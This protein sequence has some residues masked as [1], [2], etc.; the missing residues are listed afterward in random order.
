MYNY[1][2]DAKQASSFVVNKNKEVYSFLDFDNKKDFEDASKGFIATIDDNFIRDEKGNVVYDT[3]IHSFLDEVSEMDAPNTVNPSLWRQGRLTNLNGLFKVVDGIYQIRSFDLANMTAIRGNTG[4]ILIDVLTC[5]ETAKAGMDLL[6]KHVEDL[7]IKA[8]IYTHSHLD[9]F[10]GIKGIVTQEEVDNGN[11]EIIAPYNFTFETGSENVIAGNAMARRAD[12]QGG[13]SVE[14]SPQGGVGIGLGAGCASGKVTLIKPT[15]EL[16]NEL[17]TKLTIDGVDFEFTECN[18]T[19]AVSEFII[20]VPKYETLCTSEV[21]CHNL[22]N[23][24][25]PRGAQ[26]RSSLKWA[27]SIDNM[28]R[29][30]GDRTEYIVA[31]H[32]WPTFGNKDCIDFLEKQR[33]IYLY[34]HNETVRLIN[35]GVTIRELP[36]EF[37]L[38]PELEKTWHTRGYYG[39]INHNV[40]AIYQF[41]LG[42]Y[43]ANPSTNLEIHPSEAGEKLIEMMD[44]VENILAKCSKYMENGD[45]YW[46]CE[47]LNKVVFARPDNE[48]VK[49][50]L[51]DALEQIGYMEE[52][53]IRRNMYL[54]GAFELRNGIKQKGGINLSDDLMVGLT[55]EQILDFIGVRYNA[56]TAS[57]KKLKIKFNFTDLNET[58]IL[59]LTNNRV[60]NNFISDEDALLTISGNKLAIVALLTSPN[61][62]EL[63]EKGIIQ[64]EGDLSQIQLLASSCDKFAPNFAIVTP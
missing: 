42:W 3:K 41:Y 40:K 61:A 63:L 45:F 30:Y 28:I 9:H 32:H 26:I 22:H 51:A 62:S 29:L 2:K 36:H 43:D 7:P 47:V 64:T 24:L 1:N 20:F 6:R 37:K 23:L 38:S 59:E 33:D 35:N 8:V 49:C 44:G 14:R 13:F 57:N 25:T 39:H 58:R 54:Q 10:G 12:Y 27:K 21:A 50:M 56:L 19:E 48:N 18:E 15:L 11:V 4:W 60:L 46:V 31:T 55:P 17:H 16:D 34:L 5:G 53:G 52:S